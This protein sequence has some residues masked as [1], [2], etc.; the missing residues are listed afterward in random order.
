MLPDE[1]LMPS[2]KL[3]SQTFATTT[4]TTVPTTTPTTHLN[5]L[6]YMI[7]CCDGY[8]YT[9]ITTDIKRRWRQ[10]TGQIKGGAKFFRTRK[11]QKLCFIEAN[12]NRISAAQREYQIKCFSRQEKQQLIKDHMYIPPY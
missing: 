12:H 5:W 11:P 6:V 9:G 1:T 4:P 7:E 10:H 2:T 3:K 8:L